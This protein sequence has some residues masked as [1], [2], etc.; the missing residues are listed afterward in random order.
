MWRYKQRISSNNDHHTP[1]LDARIWQGGIRRHGHNLL[2]K[3][4]VTWRP[5]IGT[6]PHRAPAT[7]PRAFHEERGLYFPEID[8][9]CVYIFGMLPGF[10]ENLLESGNLFCSA[11]AATKTALGFIQLSIISRHLGM[12]SS[13]EAK[14]RHASLVGSF[15]PVSRSVCGNDQF[16]TLSVPFRNATTLGTYTNQP[17]HP[18]FYVPLIH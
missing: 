6:H 17:N 15:T 9:A 11:T 10:L 5:A 4:T 2:S 18:A 16:A 13:R 1:L 8:E 7:L 12:H 14:Q 3:I